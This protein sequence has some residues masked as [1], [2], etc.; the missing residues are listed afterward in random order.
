MF[1]TPMA[2]R[3]F[4]RNGRAAAGR[5][6]RCDRPTPGASRPA[7]RGSETTGRQPSSQPA[8]R[9]AR[10]HR[11]SASRVQIHHVRMKSVPM[12]S[13]P[14]LCSRVSP[15]HRRCCGNRTKCPAGEF[16]RTI[17]FDRLTICFSSARHATSQTRLSGA[18]H[19]REAAPRLFRA[20]RAA[21]QLLALRAPF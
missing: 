6:W 2:P 17:I 18:S 12:K 16:R 19:L 20:H 1:G 9:K 8:G 5:L 13:V 21:L 7:G 4:P 10:Q 15:E 11:A 14:W 3:F